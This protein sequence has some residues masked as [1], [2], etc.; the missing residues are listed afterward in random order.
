MTA[1]L[2]SDFETERLRIRMGVASRWQAQGGIISPRNEGAEM[3]KN[4]EP[5]V[6]KVGPKGYV[7]GWIYVGA[8]GATRDASEAEVSHYGNV[9]KKTGAAINRQ[10]GRTTPQGVPSDVSR[11]AYHAADSAQ[12][13]YANHVV[14]PHLDD[15]LRAVGKLGSTHKLSENERADRIQRARESG[16]RS[17]QVIRDAVRN[18]TLPRA[19]PEPPSAPV[20]TPAQRASALEHIMREFPSLS[21]DI[22]RSLAD[23]D[24]RVASG[25]LQFTGNFATEQQD[26]VGGWIQSSVARH[27]HLYA[28]GPNPG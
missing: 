6:T 14:G 8:D 22:Q 10:A 18:G 2:F 21:P 7:H 19:Q 28:G 27:T 23:Y 17:R 5:D 13:S 24:A 3:T 9:M 16:D 25:E 1:G 4:I 11:A 26:Q 20:T 15:A 12:A